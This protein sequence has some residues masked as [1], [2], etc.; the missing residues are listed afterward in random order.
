MWGTGWDESS[1]KCGVRLRQYVYSGGSLLGMREESLPQVI[2]MTA[3]DF[4]QDYTMP[5][6][7]QIPAYTWQL[8]RTRT[9]QIDVEV[10]FRMNVE[11]DGVIGFDGIGTRTRFVFDVPQWAIIST[12]A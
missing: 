12:D 9:L 6:S 1:A 8:D 7:I 11:G 4:R 3:E 2:D 5:A 10:R